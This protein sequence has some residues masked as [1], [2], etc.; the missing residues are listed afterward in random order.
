MIADGID[1]ADRAPRTARRSGEPVPVHA[2]VELAPAN[3]DRVFSITSL[4]R[5]GAPP[6]AFDMVGSAARPECVPVQPSPG[7]CGVVPWP[8]DRRLLAQGGIVLRLSS[9]GEPPV[10][11]REL[12]GWGCAPILRPSTDDGFVEGESC[13]RA[14]GDGDF[15]RAIGR[16]LD[17][18]ALRNRIAAGAHEVV[19]RGCASIDEMAESYLELFQEVMHRKRTGRRRRVPGP[20][21]PPPAAVGAA[22]V[23]PVALNHVESGLGPFPERGDVDDYLMEVDALR[24][25]D[26]PAPRT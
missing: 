21:L 7:G 13:L 3:V 26:R 14:E 16:L 15:A 9:G 2:C 12:V 20:I 8:M 1:V 19:R 24:R 17:D 18:P 5:G 25:G 23:F 4:V 11:L 6:A 22:S 10:E